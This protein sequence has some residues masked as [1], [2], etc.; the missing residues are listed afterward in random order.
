M[1]IIGKGVMIMNEFQVQEILM[2]TQMHPVIGKSRNFFIAAPFLSQIDD[3]SFLSS[4]SRQ[5]VITK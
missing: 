1:C 3:S 2:Q 5:K 4:L